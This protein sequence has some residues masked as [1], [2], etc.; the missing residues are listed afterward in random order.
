MR[1]DLEPRYADSEPFL[2]ECTMLDPRL[3]TTTFP[4]EIEKEEALKVIK[5]QMT[6]I[7][8]DDARVPDILVEREDENNNSSMAYNATD[9]MDT[10]KNQSSRHSL[11]L[12][13]MLNSF[14]TKNVPPSKNDIIDAE[15]KSYMSE[16]ILEYKEDPL[17]WW[18]KKQKTYPVLAQVA[19]RYLV[20]Q[21][22][23]V[24]SERI[25]STAGD[26]VSAHRACLDPENVD[27]LIFVKT[28]IKM[29]E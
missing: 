24:P 19:S 15:V 6:S 5:E 21:G 13:D 17:K 12:G 11:G 28:N 4:S 8:N 2:I 20:M 23:S 7:I 10:C 1:A 22:T 14:I 26:L 27:M 3:K 9:T 18:R 16:P 29:I 25:F